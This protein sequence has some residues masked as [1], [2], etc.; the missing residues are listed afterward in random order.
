MKVKNNEATSSA[1]EIKAARKKLNLKMPL[2]CIPLMLLA[3]LFSYISI[4][5]GSNR[6]LDENVYIVSSVDLLVSLCE[7]C[8]Y[9]VFVAFIFY[10][11][12]KLK[13]FTAS[14][15]IFIIASAIRYFLATLVR[16]LVYRSVSSDDFLFASMALA[17]DVLIIGVMAIISFLISKRTT[18]RESGKK[19][20]KG[21]KALVP[22][23]S[24]AIDR[25]IFISGIIW[26]AI[27]IISQIIYD[28]QSIS[29]LGAP[30]GK[31]IVWMII[32]YLFDILIFP[33]FCLVAMSTVKLIEEK[34]IR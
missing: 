10:S 19:S 28:V 25:S 4:L 21:F 6:V 32:Y 5:V 23:L 16:I 29:L 17:L 24:R 2:F 1:A 26:A 11:V 7:I 3:V 20:A 31:E 22:D 33:V 15:V 9:A 12:I 13:S 14:F 34:I 30:T 18:A 27:K 8:A